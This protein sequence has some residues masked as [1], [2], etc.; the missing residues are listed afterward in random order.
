MKLFY[1]LCLA[2]QVGWFLTIKS[3][4]R[5]G[6]CKRRS[7][8]PWRPH[9]LKKES[10][11]RWTNSPGAWTSTANAISFPMF[12][13]IP[14]WQCVWHAG[15]FAC[16]IM[17]FDHRALTP[18]KLTQIILSHHIPLFKKVFEYVSWS[19]PLTGSDLLLSVTS[20]MKRIFPA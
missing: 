9:Q 20:Y 18:T 10:P 17:T 11:H 7:A 15:P 3:Y 1:L 14:K 2:S 4:L 19:M 13:W 5:L 12:S 6:Y 16:T 8:N